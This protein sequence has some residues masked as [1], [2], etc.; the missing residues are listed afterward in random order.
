MYNRK[1][2]GDIVSGWSVGSVE[3]EV[4]S[5]SGVDGQPPV[6]GQ[7]HEADLVAFDVTINIKRLWNYYV[8]NVLVPLMLLVVLSFATYLIP[9]ER[10][11]ARLAL[12]VTLFLSLTAM[13]FMINDILPRSR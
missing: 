13:Q 7:E 4:E 5:S 8:V 10:L 1:G 9:R 3:I 11:D 6:A 2:E 12:T